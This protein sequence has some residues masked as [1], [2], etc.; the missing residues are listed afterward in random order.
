MPLRSM[1]Q[2]DSK[3]DLQRDLVQVW[4]AGSETRSLRFRR[5]CG[6]LIRFTRLARD[7]LDRF[8]F[9]INGRTEKLPV[10]P[11]VRMMI[12][13]SAFSRID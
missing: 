3:M 11:K 5:G 7:R 13:R 4:R 10:S 1:A 12:C 2:Q 9:P 8:C 6:R